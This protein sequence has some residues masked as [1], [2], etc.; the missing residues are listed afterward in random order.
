MVIVPALVLYPEAQVAGGGPGLQEG[1]EARAAAGAHATVPRGG[2]LIPGYKGLCALCNTCLHEAALL[3]LISQLSIGIGG[4]WPW[5]ILQQV[6]RVFMAVFAG[7]CRLRKYF[8]VCLTIHILTDFGAAKTSAI[9][10]QPYQSSP[11][12]QQPAVF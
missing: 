4:V 2:F 5:S 7:T 8:L 11:A 12:A 6:A 3:G 10:C 1:A 9:A